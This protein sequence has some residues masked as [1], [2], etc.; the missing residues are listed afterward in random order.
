[1]DSPAYMPSKNGRAK[2]AVGLCRSII[3]LNSPLSEVNLQELISAFYNREST[4][5]GPGSAFKR[6]NGREPRLQLPTLPKPL[7]EDEVKAQHLDKFRRQYEKHKYQKIEI[8]DSVLIFDP[9]RRTFSTS[10]TVETFEP[11]PDLLDQR[12]YDIRLSSGVL[13]KCNSLWMIPMKNL[14]H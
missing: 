7:S 14:G 3:E 1:M 8:G 9:K 13:R 5:R 4:I 10:G 6:M 11:L 2:P 12:D